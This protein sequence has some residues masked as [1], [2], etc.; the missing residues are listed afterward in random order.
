MRADGRP[1]PPRCRTVGKKK[2]G[3]PEYYG[4]DQLREVWLF[5]QL[6]MARTGKSANRVC[7]T[8]GL[9]WV[10]GGRGGRALDYT[11]TGQTL[12][13]W[14]QRAVRVL[15]GEREEHD[16]FLRALRS[17]KCSSPREADPLPLATW[18]NDELQFRLAQPDQPGDPSQ[19]S[20][21]RHN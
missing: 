21:F 10:V 11:V 6:L 12:R 17:A 2:A 20:L 5:V 16:G 3:R 15:K 4:D 1:Q 13:R 9:T 14:Y 19:A 7:L 18:W 8:H